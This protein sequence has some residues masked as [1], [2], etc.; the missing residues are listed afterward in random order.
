[1]I[2]S[3]AQHTL[4]VIFDVSGVQS[5]TASS[6]YRSCFIKAELSRLKKTASSFLV[7]TT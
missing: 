7:I 2:S 1:M 6:C 4:T 3:F 5:K